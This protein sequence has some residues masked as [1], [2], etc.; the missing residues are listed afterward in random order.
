MTDSE[1]ES[2][3]HIFIEGQLEFVPGKELSKHPLTKKE[4]SWTFRGHNPSDEE[5][6]MKQYIYPR[7]DS[8]PP[9]EVAQA[10]WEQDELGFNELETLPKIIFSHENI[11]FILSFFRDF[12]REKFTEYKS[13]YSPL[14]K[15]A[16]AENKVF[17]EE[18]LSLGFNSDHKD[19]SGKSPKDILLEKQQ[20][21]KEDLERLTEMLRLTE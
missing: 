1:E 17:F 4:L 6:L 7:F 19:P 21:A 16:Y 5:F 13:V 11:N 2:Y 10:L 3:F 9:K 14:R 8:R 18:L 20:K 12:P 15:A